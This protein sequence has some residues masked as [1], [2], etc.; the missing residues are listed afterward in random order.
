MPNNVLTRIVFFLLLCCSSFLANAQYANES[1][2]KFDSVPYTGAGDQ[3][4]KGIPDHHGGAYEITTENGDMYVVHYNDSLRLLWECRF[5]SNSTNYDFLSDIVMGTNDLI[6][7]TGSVFK[8]GS[9]DDVFLACLD[10]TGNVLWESTWNGN[11]NRR[12]AAFAM[13]LLPNGNIAVAGWTEFGQNQYNNLLQVWSPTGSIISYQEITTSA[14]WN[15]FN[16][17]HDVKVTSQNTIIVCGTNDASGSNS[18]AL[19]SCYDITGTALLWSQRYNFAN[20]YGDGFFQMEMDASGIYVCG[21]ARSSTRMVLQHYSYAGVLQWTIDTIPAV[22]AY[23]LEIDHSGDICVAVSDANLSVVKVSPAGAIQWQYHYIPPSLNGTDHPLSIAVDTADNIYVGGD[24]EAPFLTSD[25]A[26]LRLDPAGTLDWVHVRDG[27][28]LNDYDLFAHV[29]VDDNYIFAAGT[30]WNASSTGPFI[31][32]YDL[33]GS[34]A[35]ST[36]FNHAHGGV[37]AYDYMT[38]DSVG[39]IF[40]ASTTP[41]ASR[42]YLSKRSDNGNLLWSRTFLDS[43]LCYPK[44]LATDI[45]G[46][47]YVTGATQ[48]LASGEDVLTL[49]YDPAGNLV[50]VNTYSGAGVQTDVGHSICLDTI[51]NVYVGATVTD[52]GITRNVSV[53]KYDPAGNLAWRRGYSGNDNSGQDDIGRIGMDGPNTL[54]VP[55]TEYNLGSGLDMGLVRLDSSGNTIW[56]TSWT[57]SA[58]YSDEGFFVSVFGD[59]S[60]ALAGVTSS[61]ATGYDILVQRIDTAGLLLWTRTFGINTSNAG[62]SPSD[63]VVLGDRLY[64]CGSESVSSSNNSYSFFVMS[65]DSSGNTIWQNLLFPILSAASS[66][67]IDHDSGI[68]GV[69][70][71]DN[72]PEVLVTVFFDPSGTIID[73]AYFGEEYDDI[74]RTIKASH[75]GFVVNGRAEYEATHNSHQGISVTIKYCQGPVIECSSDTI[76]CTGDTVQLNASTGFASYQWTPANSIDNAAIHN[77]VSSAVSTTTYSVT[78]VNNYGCVSIDQQKISVRPIPQ[79]Y[80]AP[81]VANICSGDTLTVLISGVTSCTWLPVN[82]LADP[83]ALSN[84]A[85]PSATQDYFIT[86]SDPWGCSNVDTLHINVVLPPNVFFTQPLPDSVCLV[87]SPITLT[88]GAPGGGV[89]FGNGISGNTFSPMTAGLGTSNINYIYTDSITGCDASVSGIIVVDS[90]IAQGVENYIVQQSWNY[91][92]N[93]ADEQIILI[94][95]EQFVGSAKLQLIDVAGKIV[96]EKNELNAEQH[97]SIPVINIDEGIYYLIIITTDYCEFKKI[98]VKH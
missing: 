82:N 22:A 30:L 34:L 55:M 45:Y 50:W 19:I 21:T 63:I 65:L 88:N 86:G 66:I 72:A 51:G 39:N 60:I 14:A 58:N 42:I 38:V 95:S 37:G 2:V 16:I 23:N 73:T 89:Y 36:F 6:Y 84:Y 56:R 97:F 98:V 85:W 43:G 28:T 68:I 48:R 24:I 83:A 47:V 8:H 1:W 96:F 29:F 49:K 75:G 41:S 92:P 7:V 93:P 54:Y 69:T 33:N 53:M 70:G 62:D 71:L 26:L 57:G 40:V 78:A 15:V 46:N 44:A 74:G 90:C 80:A 31:S 18:E 64:L 81:A 12:D 27:G 10:T 4:D 79:I 20:G 17:F 94:P 52:S 87:S 59:H 32:K 13:T 25:Q 3:F 61:A 67:D 77:P 5:S 35:D 91:Y 76:I 11:A 9:S